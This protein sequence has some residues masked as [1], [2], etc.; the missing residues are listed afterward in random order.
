MANKRLARIRRN[1]KAVSWED[2][3]RELRAEGF[4]AE[5]T[6]GSHVVYRHPKTRA[7]ISVPRRRPYLLP[8]YV[9]E[10][11]VLLDAAIRQREEEA[12]RRRQQQEQEGATHD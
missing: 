7:T 8:V 10:A 11:L 5:E 9:G 3:D 12:H 6:G 2:L 1:P 4:A